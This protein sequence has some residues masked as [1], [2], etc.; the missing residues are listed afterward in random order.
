MKYNI[1]N[2]WLINLDTETLYHLATGK[3]VKVGEFQ[4]KLLYVLIQ[5]AGTLC[6]KDYLLETV[7]DDR[8]VGLNSLTNAIHAL[9][10]FLGDDGKNQSVIKT[11][12][13]KGYVLNLQCCGV[14]PSEDTSHE[15]EVLAPPSSALGNPGVNG[16]EDGKR[17]PDAKRTG[18]VHY[19]IVKNLIVHSLL[20]TTGFQLLNAIGFMVW[21]MF[22]ISLDC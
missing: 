13:G 4:F 18:K 16:G 8:I 6:Q 20:V 3:E 12:P 15:S 17:S 5:N 1:V 21:F 11:V 22:N 2:G 10:T 14:Q 19:A 9:R 7:W